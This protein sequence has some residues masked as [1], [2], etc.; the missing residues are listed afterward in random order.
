[1]DSPKAPSEAR[2]KFAQELK[3]LPKMSP[4][5]LILIV[6]WSL[7]MSSLDS[8]IVNIANPN[9][10]RDHNFVPEGEIIPT[11]LIQW[12]NDLYSISFAAMAIPAA[13]ISDR[14]GVTIANRIGVVGFVIF[15]ALCGASRF[16][17]YKNTWQ[18]GGFYVL[19]V[20]RLFQGVFGAV[21]MA[22]TMTLCGILVEQKDIP[23]S[24]ANN[25]L[26]FA[27][28]TALGPVL[29]GVITQYLGW[30]YC[31]F[32]NIIL[33]AMSFALCWFYIPK[34][35]KFVEEKFDYLGGFIIM[36]SLIVLIM[37]LTYIPPESEEGIIHF[38]NLPLG[39][40]LTVGGLAL[41]VFFVWWELRH[42]FAMLPRGIL[43]NKKIVLGLIAS[44]FNFAM[45]TATLFQMPFVY[46]TMRC[47]T[48]TTSGFINLVTPFAQIFASISAAFL[49]K[50]VAS[51]YTKVVTAVMSIGLVIGL[52]FVIKSELYAIILVLVFYSYNLGIYFS[53]N[54]MF[55]M[56]SATPDIRGM[57]GGTVQSFRETGL[58]IG[59]AVVNL[60]NELYL[61]HK[62]PKK[63]IIDPKC[64]TAPFFEYRNVQYDAFKITNL[65]MSAMGVLSLLFA[66]LSGFNIHEKKLIGYPKEKDA[67]TEEEKM[68]L[69]KNEQNA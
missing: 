6:G 45:M 8:T 50:K 18:Y 15:S 57:L 30:E 65:V 56:Q 54:G 58:A 40:G 38:K 32:I 55:L 29:G 19:L 5:K 44:L 10:Q 41:L 17:S 68:P 23:R 43:T 22:T 24:I 49:A 3:A 52:G 1:M 39:I 48:P 16:I 36:I 25:S 61:G 59:I 21:N 47:Y 7:G 60:S 37:G 14:I 63:P 42:P 26:A 4:G 66:V 53:S 20:A 67:Q 11:K 31:F 9:I 64:E 35:P 34:T 62:W 12:I 33:G 51:L 46:Q 27:V 2:I 69:A 28:A 13:K